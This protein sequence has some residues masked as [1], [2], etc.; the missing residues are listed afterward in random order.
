MINLS[1]TSA[2][3]PLP[4]NAGYAAAK[5]HVLYLSEAVNEELKGTGVSVTAVCPGPVP[6]EFVEL[7]DAQ[8]TQ[9]MPGFTW[10]TAERVVRDALRAADKGQRSVVPGGALVKAAFV[11]NRRVPPGLALLVGKR[12]MRKS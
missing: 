4:F 3:Q 6:T 5:A 9:R 11:P 8:F 2:F 7:N 1:S 12:L 10:V